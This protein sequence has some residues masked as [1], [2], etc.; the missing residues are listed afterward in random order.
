MHCGPV[1]HHTSHS[2]AA[3]NTVRSFTPRYN[4]THSS[5][6]H[7]PKQ[8]GGDRCMARSM[9]RMKKLPIRRRQHTLHILRCTLKSQYYTCC[10]A[11]LAHTSSMCQARVVHSDVLPLPH[12]VLRSLAQ[13][14]CMHNLLAGTAAELASTLHL[15]Q[16]NCRSSGIPFGTSRLTLPEPDLHPR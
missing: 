5:S 8:E 9:S 12:Q 6:H 1:V 4:N 10:H 13:T 14:R 2:S 16:V 15:T 7:Q 11:S 3:N